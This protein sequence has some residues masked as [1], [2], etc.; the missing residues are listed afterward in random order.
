MICKLVGYDSSNDRKS[1]SDLGPKTKAPLLYYVSSYYVD[2]IVVILQS[3]D[4]I[5]QS[6]KTNETA[7]DVHM[8]YLT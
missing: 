3:H 8:I 6:A 7:V 4:T 1:S 5:N 2:M